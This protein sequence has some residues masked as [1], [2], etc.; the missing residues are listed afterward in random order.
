MLS[1]I[2]ASRSGERMSKQEASQG[3][4]AQ[5]SDAQSNHIQRFDKSSFDACMKQASFFAS[6]FDQRRQF[7][8]KISFGVW[9][10]LALATASLAGKNNVPIW[11]IPIPCLL[12]GRW[13]IE[14][15]DK[16]D[17]EKT[18]FKR[19]RDQA[20]RVLR[21]IK[22]SVPALPGKRTFF[23]RLRLACADWSAQFSFCCTVVLAAALYWLNHGHPIGLTI[24][25]CKPQ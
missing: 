2:V 5:K 9:T 18:M 25:V 21:R 1:V 12:H 7:E 22:L 15:C 4:G 13:L 16:N 10:L 11:F 19:Y 23:Q 20:D 24:A 6:R 8:W 17:F 3:S 14:V